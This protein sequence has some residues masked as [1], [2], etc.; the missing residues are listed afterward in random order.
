MKASEIRELS[1]EERIRKLSE[2]TEGL[3]NLRFQHGAGQLESPKKIEQTKHDIA[4]LKTVI[5]E[6][7]LKKNKE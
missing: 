1:Q 4:R 5:Q 2:L 7:N 3:F 6:Y